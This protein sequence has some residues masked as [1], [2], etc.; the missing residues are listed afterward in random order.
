MRQT[1][2]FHVCTVAIYVARVYSNSL[3]QG[4]M[5]CFDHLAANRAAFF[6]KSGFVAKVCSQG[7]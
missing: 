5:V 1:V 6:C 7:V 2:F 3:Q 4:A